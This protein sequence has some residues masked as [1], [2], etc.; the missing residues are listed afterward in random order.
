MKIFCMKYVVTFVGGHNYIIPD[1]AIDS[2]RRA[3]GGKIA[4][5][6]PVGAMQFQKPEELPSA[7]PTV[8]FDSM[9]LKQL[10]DYCIEKQLPPSLWKVTNNVLKLRKILKEYNG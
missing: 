5:I 1:T 8:D 6:M 9:K 7:M 3:H 10:Q 2:Q 4:S